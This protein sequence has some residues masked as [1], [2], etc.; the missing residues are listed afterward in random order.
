MLKSRNSNECTTAVL[1][2][3]HNLAP[4][5]DTPIFCRGIHYSKVKVL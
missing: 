2:V 4:N 3:Q 5:K 1:N